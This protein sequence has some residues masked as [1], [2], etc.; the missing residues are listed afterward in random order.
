[1]ETR[2]HLLIIDD[3]EQFTSNLKK[4]LVARGFQVATALSGAAGLTTME[5][6]NGPF[7]VILLDVKMPGMDGVETLREIKKRED[8]CQVIMLTGHASIASGAQ[9]IRE[10]AYDYLMK[11]CDIEDLMEKV[12]EACELETIRRQ[13]LLWPR[14]F[15]AE[16]VFYAFKKLFTD[17]VTASALRLLTRQP[18]ET[19]T[20]RLFV[21]DHDNRLCGEVTRRDLIRS[22]RETDPSRPLTW[23]DLVNHPERLGQGIVAEVMC[24][25]KTTVRPA[26]RLEDVAVKMIARH[27]RCAPVVKGDEMVG[28]IRIQDVLLH[29]G[30]SPGRQRLGGPLR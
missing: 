6:T 24:A 18:G 7:D 28:I 3:E 8:H 1:M 29:A 13:P 25:A 23:S 5:E 26:D 14:R 4:L 20:E 9:A 11:P 21:I 19:A 10:G 27:C 17:D 2:P 16:I 12:L 15:V 22:V 30:G